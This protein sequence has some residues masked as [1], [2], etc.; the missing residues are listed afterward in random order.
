MEEIIMTTTTMTSR[1]RST[2]VLLKPQP[3]PITGIAGMKPTL[4][5]GVEIPMTGAATMG[6]MKLGLD[7]TMTVVLL[8]V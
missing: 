3:K 1:D 7:P 4:T 6:L 8:C 2:L 5:A